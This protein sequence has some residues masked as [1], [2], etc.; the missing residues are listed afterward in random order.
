MPFLN[1]FEYI[2][3]NVFISPIIY[4]NEI[5]CEWDIPFDK[6][7]ISEVRVY[8]RGKLITKLV[9][10]SKPGWSTIVEKDSPVAKVFL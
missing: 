8:L 5:K 4:E 10:G 2:K 9:P 6:E 1:P 7:F 3:A